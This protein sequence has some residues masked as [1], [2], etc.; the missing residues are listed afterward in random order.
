[1]KF[2]VYLFIPTLVLILGL[3][4][5]SC[6]Q[7]KKKQSKQQ[8]DGFRLLAR[9]EEPKKLELDE[10]SI[11]GVLN[12]FEDQENDLHCKF[13][14]KALLVFEET[15][16]SGVDSHIEKCLQPD[17][18]TREIR[19]NMERKGSFLKFLL[20]VHF[21]EHDQL[22]GDE[23]EVG[24]RLYTYKATFK[25]IDSRGEEVDYNPTDRS[26]VP[27]ILH[28]K[29]SHIGKTLTELLTF[30]QKNK[31]D[32]CLKKGRLLSLSSQKCF[33]DYHSNK[34]FEDMNVPEFDPNSLEAERKL[35]IENF[36]RQFHQ[37]MLKPI[38]K[39]KISI[40]QDGNKK[41][42]EKKELEVFHSS[43][44]K[45]LSFDAESLVEQ[46]EREGDKTFRF[47]NY[48]FSID[49]E[50]SR[51]FEVGIY[52]LLGKQNPGRMQLFF[53]ING[54]YQTWDK[55]KM[56][57][58]DILHPNM[59][60]LFNFFDVFNKSPYQSPEN[61]TDSGSDS[62]QALNVAYGDQGMDYEPFF[63]KTLL[64]YENLFMEHLNLPNIA[65]KLNHNTPL[66][67]KASQDPNEVGEAYM[68][69]H[70]VVFTKFKFNGIELDN[71]E[72]DDSTF[73]Q[74]MIVDCSLAGSSFARAKFHK[75]DFGGSRFSLLTPAGDDLSIATQPFHLTEIK[76]INL[77]GA[78]FSGLREGG[79]IVFLD[80]K[81]IG[82]QIEDQQVKE[83]VIDVF[84]LLGSEFKWVDFGELA[85]RPIDPDSNLGPNMMGMRLEECLIQNQR[86]FVN[87]DLR[88]AQIINTEISNEMSFSGAV[89]D[90]ETKFINSLSQFDCLDQKQ[91][92]IS[93][94][95]KA[96]NVDKINWNDSGCGFCKEWSGDL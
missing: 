95:G 30:N 48:T 75:V 26:H 91:N 16:L 22:E 40:L 52:N 25:Q 3:G 17:K 92:F 90:S 44:S 33:Y 88:G 47:L 9:V 68:Q 83:K 76:Q 18:Q 35:Q 77:K 46:T 50:H 7:I 23:Y 41:D 38:A 29:L 78:R 58:I 79:N 45:G 67:R 8:D 12:H 10:G 80:L 36:L 57:E 2:G 85:M 60:H 39:G 13:V 82:K 65:F 28:T 5:S 81:Q 71:F 14:E 20:R 55:D 19:F 56:H 74:G 69:Q 11:Y 31:L 64:K 61:S 84:S 6:G 53:K 37:V 59:V 73:E 32:E 42:G 1:M 49:E 62:A 4:L 21:K 43:Y 27:D 86:F 51:N 34:T 96:H 94:F 93:A 89:F 87:A 15:Y 70:G 72:F 24:T 66:P 63:R 54:E